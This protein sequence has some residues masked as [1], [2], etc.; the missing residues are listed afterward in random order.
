MKKRI[1]LIVALLALGMLIA[2]CISFVA[3]NQKAEKAEASLNRNS[4]NVTFPAGSLPQNGFLDLSKVDFASEAYPTF[5]SLEQEY[6]ACR[7]QMIGTDV[8]GN[9]LLMNEV[10]VLDKLQKCLDDVSDTYDDYYMFAIAPGVFSPFTADQRLGMQRLVDC[11]ANAVS[12]VI[13]QT[14]VTFRLNVIAITAASALNDLSMIWSHE[15]PHQVELNGYT[16]YTRYDESQRIIL[17]QLAVFLRVKC[18]VCDRWRPWLDDCPTCVTYESV[19][20]TYEENTA[21]ITMK[22]ADDGTDKPCSLATF[23]SKAQRAVEDVREE[24]TGGYIYPVTLE[25]G[26]VVYSRYHAAMYNQYK[27][28]VDGV[29]DRF[30]GEP[31]TALGAISY[32][33]TVYAALAALHDV[34]LTETDEY[35]CPIEHNGIRFYSRYGRAQQDLL[36]Q[37]AAYV[38]EDE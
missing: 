25:D 14:P 12:G 38:S 24:N 15:Y 2:V 13:E 23:V 22:Y 32:K 5:R 34:S 28:L 8:N 29:S 35:W 36:W 30:P 17:E 27:L 1:T 4:S 26:T 21:L 18:D 11:M 37:C 3:L 20:A 9:E 10:T 33:V 6:Y 7:N 19:Q 31:D 16:F